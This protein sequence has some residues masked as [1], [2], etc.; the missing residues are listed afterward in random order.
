MLKLFFKFSGLP[1]SCV[2]APSVHRSGFVFIL[3]SQPWR[4][5]I[6]MVLHSLRSL[7]SVQTHV[8][9]RGVKL[10]AAD[11][12][13]EYRTGECFLWSGFT[14]TTTTIE[15]TQKFL[16]FV[17]LA[18][19]LIR[20]DRSPRRSCAKPPACQCHPHANAT[21]MPMPRARVLLGPTRPI[22]TLI[23]APTSVFCV[24]A[25]HFTS[26]GRRPHTLYPQHDAADWNGPSAVFAAPGRERGA[27]AAQSRVRSRGGPS[28]R[29]WTYN[30]AVP[31][32][33]GGGQPAGL[34][35]MHL[36]AVVR[37]LA[38]EYS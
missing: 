10:S 31:A 28:Q 13:A 15:S 14:S 27:F 5:Y 25:A 16:G 9:F 36:L 19:V 32:G 2:R 6:W 20:G 26:T 4:D 3:L 33:H 34:H 38:V 30:A 18:W 29:R 11:L 21:R 1:C 12:G 24:V 23:R 8:L 35:L 7:P 37:V 22:I 17:F